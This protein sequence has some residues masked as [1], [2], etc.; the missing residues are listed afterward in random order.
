MKQQLTRGILVALEGVDGSG[1][2]TLLARLTSL[3]NVIIQSV[4][5]TK[6]PGS[7]D[8]PL[9]QRIRTIVQEKQIPICAKAE[10]LLFASDRAQ[11]F[12][13]VIL[14]ALDKNSLIIS[15]RM[16]DSS[17]VYQGY[18]RGLDLAMI[19]TISTWASNGK[20]PDLVLYVQV[21]AHVAA[22]RIAKRKEELTSF[23]K[24]IHTQQLIDGYNTIFKHR[25]NV[26]YLNGEQHPETVAHEAF[27]KLMHWLATHNALV[28]Q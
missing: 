1:K 16:V 26:I 14:P 2:S 17:L 15:D 24:E 27:S 19:D 9:G 6:E 8:V 28:Q 11:H 10:S 23:E 12:N 18:G 7:L 4:V 25:D 20:K 21:S 13:D 5:S 3:C 22:S